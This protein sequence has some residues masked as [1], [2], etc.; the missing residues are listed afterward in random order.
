MRAAA[1]G[2]RTR[3]C[4]AAVAVASLRRTPSPCSADSSALRAPRSAHRAPLTPPR[5]GLRRSGLRALTPRQ[6]LADRE[7][8]GLDFP[9]LPYW[10]EDGKSGVKLTQSHAILQHVARLGGLE[11]TTGEV[12]ATALML[13]ELSRELRD[14]YVKLSYGSSFETRKGAFI[15]SLDAPLA[16][17]EA[18]AAKS[19]AF[20]C[21]EFTFVDLVWA[22]LI[23]QF[24]CLAPDCLAAC[25]TLQAHQQAV[26]ALPKMAAYRASAAFV[27]HPY[28]NPAATFR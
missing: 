4:G 26:W 27:D 1:P 11:G 2:R 24:L 16:R 21:G 7:A 13:L 19:G 18:F 6:W 3:R 15:A 14:P 22:D 8:L 20:L 12:Q 23:E 17:L 10:L 28:N 25:P 5:S 9:N